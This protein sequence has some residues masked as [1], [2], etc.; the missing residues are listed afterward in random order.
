MLIFTSFAT[1][2]KQEKK[3]STQQEKNHPL[4]QENITGQY[5][6]SFGHKISPWSMVI[7]HVRYWN[8]IWLQN[9]I[10]QNSR[11]GVEVW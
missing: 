8:Y 11:S 7:G 9:I 3:S 10:H 1:M 5:G 4:K 6:A 2:L